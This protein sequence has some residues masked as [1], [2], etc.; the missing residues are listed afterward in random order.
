MAILIFILLALGTTAYIMQIMKKESYKSQSPGNSLCYV[1]ENNRGIT[2]D[3]MKSK[4]GLLNM[5]NLTV[6][7]ECKEV[8][9]KHM[10]DNLVSD[11]SQTGTKTCAWKKICLYRNWEFIPSI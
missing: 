4:L 2:K 5:I 10:A 7:E 1:N 9:V 8:L 6:P 3:S 11:A